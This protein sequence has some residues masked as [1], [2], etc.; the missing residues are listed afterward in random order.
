M[1]R[2]PSNPATGMPD[3]MELVDQVLAAFFDLR[4][5]GQRLGLVTDSG[6]GSWGVLRAAATEPISMAELARRRGVSRQYIQ[7]IAT[8]LIGEGYLEMAP[9][10]EHRRSGLLTA[11]A[12]G[13]RALAEMNKRVMATLGPLG[14]EFSSREVAAAARTVAKLRAGIARISTLA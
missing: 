3:L 4:I 10:P 5:A 2:K 8:G 9:N 6:G 14:T 11:T 7:K 13:R 1:S 12:A